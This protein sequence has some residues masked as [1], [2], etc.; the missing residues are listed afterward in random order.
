MSGMKRDQRL[1]DTM[2]TRSPHCAA[3]GSPGSARAFRRRDVLGAL[4][5]L[6]CLLAGAAAPVRAAPVPRPPRVPRV[7]PPP[8][9]FDVV[10]DGSVIGEHRVDFKRADRGYSAETRI[11]IKVQI[12][13]V[14][15]FEYHHRSTEVWRND[16]LQTFHSETSDDGSDFFV[17]GR[18]TADGFEMT[19]RKGSESA[20]ADVMVASFWTPAIPQQRQLIDPQRGRLKDQQLLGVD[21]FTVDVAGTP[22][23]TTRYR[24][25][26]V[27]DG[28]VAYDDQGRWL[29]AELQ[30]KGSAILYRLHG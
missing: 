7:P 14:T 17:D 5:T 9:R 28:W 21:T 24:V 13:G 26:G 2:G 30:R 1:I 22:V 15:A 12:L 6:P 10:R 18:A 19:N 16:R 3:T 25:S 4:A 8:I 20:P 29:A 11:D 23:A 27:S